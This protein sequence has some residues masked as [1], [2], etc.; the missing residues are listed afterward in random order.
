MLR[1]GLVDPAKLKNVIKT[2]VLLPTLTLSSVDASAMTRNM[3]SELCIDGNATR[4]VGGT[5]WKGTDG[6]ANSYR[7]SKS[8]Y[9]QGVLLA[10][11]AITIDAQVHT[12]QQAVVLAA[13]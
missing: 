5:I 12:M 10:K 7:C 3:C 2:I 13:A 9:S 4:V 8:I 11:L 6:A 1:N